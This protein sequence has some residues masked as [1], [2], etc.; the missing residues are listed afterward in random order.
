M[1][2]LFPSISSLLSLRTGPAARQACSFERAPH[3]QNPHTPQRPRWV[4]SHQG[5]F[6]IV[7]FKG[8]ETLVCSDLF[9]VAAITLLL[10]AAILDPLILGFCRVLVSFSRKIAR[11]A[12]GSTA[13]LQRRPPAKHLPPSNHRLTSSFY[14]ASFAP[15]P[16]VT[17]QKVG[18]PER[19]CFSEKG[20][21]HIASSV[22]SNLLKLNL[23]LRPPAHFK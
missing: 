12:A 21:Q 7:I 19:L 11:R 20:K 23:C 15:L 13:R 17:S 16:L 18:L 8:V 3:Q 1:N 14:C 9:S 5:D 22:C 4:T 2:L 10:P 6:D